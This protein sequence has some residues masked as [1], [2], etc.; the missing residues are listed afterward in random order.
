VQR[1]REAR[2]EHDDDDTR[3]AA[4]KSTAPVLRALF[5]C[6]APL[7]LVGVFSRFPLD[8]VAHVE[9]AARMASEL[10]NVT[11]VRYA[12]ED[13]IREPPATASALMRASELV[14]RIF[15]VGESLSIPLLHLAW[16]DAD[17]PP[18]ALARGT[19][20][21][22]FLDWAEPL[23]D[24]DDRVRLAAVAND[25]IAEILKL[26]ARLKARPSGPRALRN[27]M[28]WVGDERYL[29]AAEVALAKRVVAPL[30]RRNIVV[31]LAALP[32]AV[33]AAL[34]A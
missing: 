25:A 6:R 28:G 12:D 27:G 19:V 11:A 17:Q 15:C 9:M 29:R 3:V 20:G 5:E 2:V 32:A 13:V 33:H 31:D 34:A 26:W 1:H 8:E 30:L 14:V 22:T 18:V 16:R 21:W 10:G 7:D 24:D 23:L 4:F